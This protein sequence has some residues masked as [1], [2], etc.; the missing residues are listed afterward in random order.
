MHPGGLSRNL[1]VRIDKG[2]AASLMY[3]SYTYLLLDI[4]TLSFPLA[5]SRSE[6]FGF[7]RN[8]KYAWGAVLMTAIPFVLW[9]ILFTHLGVWSFN[10][11]FILKVYLWNLPLEE[12]L[13]FISIPFACLFIYQQ[14]RENRRLELSSM[15]AS[16]FWGM[17]A[18]VL[19][20]LG[21]M[22]GDR[23][24]TTSVCGLGALTSLLLAIFRPRYSGPLLAAVAIQY[25]PFLLVNGILTALPVVLY[26][27]DALMGMHIGTIPLEDTVY[28]FVML[29]GP[30]ALFEM[31]LQRNRA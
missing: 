30:V 25:L 10:P 11:R 19:A 29:V 23:I 8:W 9:D 28:S 13:F 14:V 2:L 6:R 12:I 7:G 17:L 5:F 21:L 3:M 16:I 20:C 18:I 1:G 31:F 27:T 4:L 26:R 15:Q 22:N 24:Y